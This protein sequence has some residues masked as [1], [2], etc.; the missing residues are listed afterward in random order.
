MVYTIEF[1]DSVKE[2]LKFLTAHQRVGLFEAIETQ[3]V[4]EPLVE[5]RNRKL[6]R[7]NPLAPWELRVGELRVF[8]EVAPEE[9]EVVRILAVGV[10]KGNRLFI[11]GIEV[12][13]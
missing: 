4:N 6:L 11:A 13:I 10:K 12:K 9:P 3:L 8:Y 2:H 1:A 5:A 7:S